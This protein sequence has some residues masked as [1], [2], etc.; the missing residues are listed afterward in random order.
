MPVV[1]PISLAEMEQA[2]GDEA[3]HLAYARGVHLRQQWF[4]DALAAFDRIGGSLNR[5]AKCARA[6]DG[7]R[8]SRGE[9]VHAALAARA[10]DA[11]NRRPGRVA[12]RIRW[13]V[14]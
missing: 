10:A 7:V 12:M 4:G 1:V 6:S 14:G 11:V 2:A 13:S 5:R 3:T 8:R 9:V